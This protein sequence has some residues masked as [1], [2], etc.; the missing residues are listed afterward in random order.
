MRPISIEQNTFRY[1]LNS[2]LGTEAQIRLIRV[3]VTEVNGPI[4]IVDAAERAD[5]TPLGARKAMKRLTDAGFVRAIGGGRKQQYEI[6]NQDTL[7][8]AIAALF[9]A[10]TDR[11]EHI[12]SSIR[13]CIEKVEPHPISAWIPSFPVDAGNP[14]KICILQGARNLSLT[15]RNLRVLFLE[16]ERELDMTIELISYTKADTPKQESGSLHLYGLPPSGDNKIESGIMSGL[17]SHE[18][19]AE[20]LTDICR[21]IGKMINKDRSIIGRAK[22]HTRLILK[23]KS[24]SA[25]GDIEEWRDILQE[26]S[27]R[28]LIH[29][30]S[31]KSERAVRL[32]QS[33]PF[34]AVLNEKEKER[35]LE[36]L[37]GEQ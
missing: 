33:C 27:V 19:K 9:S 36:E 10:E 21:I 13:K 5:L 28:R 14:I 8:Q 30:L 18:K 11:F 7:V 2:I 29:F 31:S 16:L 34:L 26:Y 22:Q 4:S 25:T 17:A 24:G 37:R 6:S 15:I 1:P 12:L 23:G 32:R 20:Q 3:M 35:V